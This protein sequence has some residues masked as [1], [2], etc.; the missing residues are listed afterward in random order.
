MTANTHKKIGP[1]LATMV[2]ASTMIGSGIFLLPASLGAVGSISILSWLLATGGAALIAG[3]FCWLSQA[4]PQAKGL[5]SYIRDA[6][7]PSTGFVIGALY[8]A[9]CIVACVAIALAV[10][11]YLSVFVPA[12]ARPPLS[13]LATVAILWLLVA[14]NILGP[15]FVAAM[16]SCSLALG[17][18]PVLLA[19]IGGWVFF[20]ADTFFASWNVTGGRPIA[21]VPGATVTAFWAFLGVESAIVLSTRVRNPG[22]DVAIGTLGG[23]AIAAMIYIAASAALMGMLPAAALAK[24]AAPF[25]DAFAPVLGAF[26]AGAVALCAM[27]KAG[28]T[29]G[30]SMLL[31]VET[32]ECESVLGHMR[33]VQVLREAPRASTPNLIFT[34]ALCSIVAVGSAS[35]TLARQFTLVTNVA[36]VMSVLVYGAASLAVLRLSAALPKT[37]RMWA[38]A[39]GIGA[40]LFSAGLAVSSEPLVLAWTAAALLMT[41]LLYACTRLYRAQR[42]AVAAR[43]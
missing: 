3:V 35:P 37:K 20:H 30:A 24:S 38:R 14:A 31:T 15:R 43:V 42:A 10:T 21:V 1:F 2:V 12:V 5:F 8:W 13:N 4:D 18:L 25:A 33:R 22:R 39:T 27:I 41:L 17:L 7:G 26:V 11:G 32:A 34:G 36:V 23:V 16:Q 29:L 9:S 6:F 28:G 40:A 19:A